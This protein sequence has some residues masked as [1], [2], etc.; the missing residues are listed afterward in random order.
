MAIKVAVAQFTAGL[1]IEDNTRQVTELIAASAAE[2]ADLAVLP[3]AA[4]FFDPAKTQANQS[5]GQA[6][7]GDF[8]AAVAEAAK[9][10]GI[11]AL[12]G[13]SESLP[14]LGDDH[15][16]SNTVVGVSS[17]GETV[18]AYRK[19][20]LYDAFG[21]RES[22][23][24]R[25]GEIGQPLV[26]QV[27]DVSVGVLTCYDL[28]FPEAFR[29]VTDA[30]ADLIALPAAWAVG[31]AKEDHWRTLVR[32]RAIENTVFLAAAGQTGPT[33]C[34]Q[35]MVVD[36]MGVELA[37]AGERPGIAIATVSRERLEQ[38]RAVNPSLSNRRFAVQ[39]S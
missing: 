9:A 36:P 19:I 6:L 27:G 28:R 39:P 18:G 26:L 12:V 22:D 5:H 11:A 14:D 7:D 17:T 10:H 8:V 13:M 33:S 4:M 3:E 16:D 35:S 25:P 20:H 1:D 30:G 21:Y 2:G 34:G 31:P 29:W 37:C 38:V 32:A 15:R 24:V 23:Q